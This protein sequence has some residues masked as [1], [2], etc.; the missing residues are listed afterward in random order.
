MAKK[1][2]IAR[3]KQR[4]EIVDRYAEKRAELKAKGDYEG[5]QKLPRN[6]SPVRLHNRDMVDGRPHGYLRKYG[7][8]RIRFREAAHKG[9]IPGVKKASW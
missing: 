4:Q 1:S 8:S 7:M 9:Q 5:L 3:E 6:A 2:K